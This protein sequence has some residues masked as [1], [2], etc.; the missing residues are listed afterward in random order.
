MNRSSSPCILDNQTNKQVE[1]I[2]ESED[3]NKHLLKSI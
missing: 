2:S 1:A 3:Y